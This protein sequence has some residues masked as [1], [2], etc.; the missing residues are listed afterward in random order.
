MSL[1]FGDRV[2]HSG[3]FMDLPLEEKIELAS[4]GGFEGLS[5]M[6]ND[7]RRA[8]GQGAS[9]P[10]L[11]ARL[12]DRGLQVGEIEVI[13]RWPHG[14]EALFEELRRLLAIADAFDARSVNICLM[15]VPMNLG[16]DAAGSIEAVTQRAEEWMNASVGSLDR[17]AEVFAALCDR[18]AEHGRMVQLEFFPWTDLDLA[19]SAAIVRQ[20]ARPNGRIHIDTWHYQRSGGPAQLGSVAGSDVACVQLSDGRAER[21]QNVTLF[22]ELG[23]RLLP[24]DG[25]FDLVGLLNHL[26]K[27]GFDG[28]VCGEVMFPWCEGAWEPGTCDPKDAARQLAR[29]MGRTLAAVLR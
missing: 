25:E 15:G 6:A 13:S 20:A 26:R 28:P 5:I 18:A 19:K 3:S 12:A 17:A 16:D 4:A 29:S 10:D 22:Q 11:V 27:T 24:G 7:Y 23:E 9:T 1:G 2:L 21:N 14:G 8:L